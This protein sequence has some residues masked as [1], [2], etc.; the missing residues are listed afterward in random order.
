MQR[1]GLKLTVYPDADHDS[2]SRTYDGSAG[3]DI[4]AWLLDHDRR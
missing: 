3:D 2:W 1:S 4:Y